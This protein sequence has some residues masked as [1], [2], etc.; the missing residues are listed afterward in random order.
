MKQ[1]VM[2]SYIARN[3]FLI[4]QFMFSNIVINN[5]LLFIYLWKGARNLNYSLR[6]IVG[7]N[8]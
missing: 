2:V 8:D 5:F 3:L 6:E 7:H 4:K 1:S